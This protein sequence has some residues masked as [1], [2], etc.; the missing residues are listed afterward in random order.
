MGTKRDDNGREMTQEQC[1][2]FLESEVCKKK[3]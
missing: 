2:E 1:M 3:I